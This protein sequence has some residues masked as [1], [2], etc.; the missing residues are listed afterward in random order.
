MGLLLENLIDPKTLSD[1]DVRQVLGI[2]FDSIFPAAI[3]R[4]EVRAAE[5]TGQ[6]NCNGTLRV[7]IMKIGVQRRLAECGARRKLGKQNAVREQLQSRQ[8]NPDFLRKE[9]G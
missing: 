6:G 4:P 9:S 5:S 2:F 3:R 1:E 7:R 8:R